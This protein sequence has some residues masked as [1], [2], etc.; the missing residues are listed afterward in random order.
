MVYIGLW[1]S[2]VKYKLMAIHHYE[3]GEL[4]Q[5]KNGSMII[6]GSMMFAHESPIQFGSPRN[7]IHNPIQ[8]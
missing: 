8:V 5:W 2:I 4:A 1:S 6:H 3:E 7:L